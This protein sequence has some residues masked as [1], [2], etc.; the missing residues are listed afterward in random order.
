M[1]DDPRLPMD[2]YR[3]AEAGVPQPARRRALRLAGLGVAVMLCGGLTDG[4][5]A[6]PTPRR[7]LIVHSFGR[8]IAPYAASVAVFRRELASRLPEPVVFIEAALDA[9]RA[10]CPAEQ[11]AFAAYLR[12]RFADPAPDL[13][14]SVAGPA[15]QFLVRW[16]D[17][18][19]PGVPLMMTA[20]DA[21]IVPRAALRPGDAAVATRIDLRRT[22]DALLRLLPDTGTIAVVLGTTPLERFW[23]QQLQQETAFLAGR[24]NVVWLDGLSLAQIKQRVAT[25]PP[26]SAVY[27]GLLVVDGDGVPHEGLQALSELH[28]VA[29]A[30]IFSIFESELGLGVVGG[31]YVSQTLAGSE[32]ARLAL[33]QLTMG[34]RAGVQELSIGMDTVAYDARELR[35][36]HIDKARLL[37]GGE[38]RFQPVSPWVQYRTAI[39]ATTAVLLAQ[40]GLIAALLLQRARRQRAEREARSLGGRLITA[41]EDEG[42]RL[43]RELHDDVTQ[44]L[45]GLS[46]ETAALGRLEDPAARRAAEQGIGTE[47]A[48]LSRDV[49]ALAYRLH[50][51]VLDDLGLE[52]ALRV[53]CERASRRGAVPVVFEGA[54]GADAV[55]GPL[56]LSLFRVAQEAL[57]NALSHAQAQR[58]GVGL[59]LDA[60]GAE[61]RVVDDG[62]GFD[63]QAGRVRASLGLASMR[64]RMALLGGRLDVRSRPGE[65]ASVIAWAPLEVA[66]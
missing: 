49:H 56:A 19:F 60:G 29:N 11:A 46:M 16:R 62:Q 9:G 36:W 21:R 64:E 58:I 54:P 53:E 42:R 41:Y 48:H 45:A 23:H 52:E 10:I 3:V 25:L 22:F 28:Q 1:S 59:R 61:L 63:P 39:L 44:R 6:G 2:P 31:P 17:A 27:F 18:I 43:G 26:R 33:Q 47:L 30:P 57:R 35:R 24:V 12:E 7:V 14:V 8:E 65:G 20:V 55:R 5:V 13:I 51:S 50:P 4:A 40:T 66:P 38:L 34:P 15:A 32:T 37:P